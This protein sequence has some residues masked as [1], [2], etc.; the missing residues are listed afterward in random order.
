[1]NKDKIEYE[2]YFLAVREKEVPIMGGVLGGTWV[3]KAS[4]GKAAEHIAKLLNQN[5]LPDRVDTI[6]DPDHWLYYQSHLED[7][8]ELVKKL[9]KQI[10]VLQDQLLLG[11]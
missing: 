10:S 5:P 7:L 1:M 9:R 11:N 2:P 6:D 4:S 8:N 3:C